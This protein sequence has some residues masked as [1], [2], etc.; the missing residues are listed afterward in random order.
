V[1]VAGASTLEEL[2]TDLEELTLFACTLA[3]LPALA[4]LRVLRI[5][6]C[7]LGALARF[8]ALEEV[9]IVATLVDDLA[10][11]A[12]LPRLR[13]AT[14]L[15]GAWGDREAARA[16]FGPRVL[17]QLDDPQ[18][19]ALDTALREA[20]LPLRYVDYK[21]QVSLVRPGVGHRV[22][23]TWP[24]RI[25]AAL[26]SPLRE[27]EAFL[28][29]VAFSDP[30]PDTS[31][32]RFLTDWEIG[33]ADDARGWIASAAAL[34]AD[35]RAWLIAFVD[36]FAAHHFRRETVAGLAREAARHRVTFPAQMIALRSQAFSTID[37]PYR[38]MR[39]RFADSPSWYHVGPIGYAS[40]EERAKIGDAHGMFPIGF[41][42]GGRL[43]LAIPL[44][45]DRRVFQYAYDQP[46]NPRFASY[47][48]L[49]AH[50]V[51][52]E[53]R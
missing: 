10:P 51:D 26:A 21:D 6:A 17:V 1:I 32:A 8:P 49:L 27:V 46:P 36:R 5:A 50:V 43:Q 33:D 38:S 53:L 24:T 45:E 20:G 34:R 3:S 19:W 37:V 16:A 14:L 35:D 52:V 4:S 41:E 11:L 2:P 7:E 44:G 23:L 12:A 22:V 13:R 30:P 42:D 15:G 25:E 9:E 48:E 28:A 31:L 18:A 47:A 40:D 39:V 29:E